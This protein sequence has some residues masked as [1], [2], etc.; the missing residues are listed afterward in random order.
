M[1]ETNII[2]AI[3]SIVENVHDTG[4]HANIIE[5]NRCKVWSKETLQ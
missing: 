2:Y 5:Y 4:A 1:I 3:S